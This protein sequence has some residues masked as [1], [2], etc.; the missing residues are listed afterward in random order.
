MSLYRIKLYKLKTVC[1]FG[2][3]DKAASKFQSFQTFRANFALATLL[4]EH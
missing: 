4:R 2:I 3:R 1:D